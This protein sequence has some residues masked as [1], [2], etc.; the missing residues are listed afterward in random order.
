V[1]LLEIAI[2][3]GEGTNRL[4]ASIGELFEMLQN[5]LAF[6]LMPMTFEIAREVAR[7]GSLLRDPADRAIVATARVHQLSLVTADQLIIESKLVP[8]VD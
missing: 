8:V 5:T 1:T 4:K 3:S 2:L 7:L 6:Q